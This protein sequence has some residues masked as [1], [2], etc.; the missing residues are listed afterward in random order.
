MENPAE[1]FEQYRPELFRLAYSMLGR[2]APAKDAV[3][4]AFLRWQKQDP[5]QIHSH[6]AYLSRIVSNLCLDELKSAQNRR[7]QYIGPNLPEP[8]VSSEEENPQNQIE[9]SES[10]SMALLFTLEQLSPVQRAVFLLREVFD[11]DYA[12]I[13]EVI[14]KTESHCRKIAQRSRDQ[15]KANRPTLEKSNPK[16]H[17]LV[18]AFIEA[19]QK[20]NISEIE[21]MLA[22]EA[23]LYSDGGGKVTAARKPIYGANKIARFMVGIQKHKEEGQTVDIIFRGINREPGMM[24]YL[25]D[26]LFN[27]WSFHIKNGIIQ[28]IFVVLNPDKLQHLPK[29]IEK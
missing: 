9:L 10:L 13:A 8:L 18:T 21:S 2:I 27:V 19:V 11:Y 6:R 26:K 15:V 23:I 16:Q 25:D 24:I 20:G 3:Q 28:N 1:L 5:D 4:E 7:E 29:K 17:E 22:E 14:D 12:S